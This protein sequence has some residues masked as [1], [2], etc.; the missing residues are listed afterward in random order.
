MLQDFTLSDYD[1]NGAKETEANLAVSALFRL[2]L[3]IRAA[4]PIFVF[5]HETRNIVFLM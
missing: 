4:H 2:Q 5:S 1:T 3:E